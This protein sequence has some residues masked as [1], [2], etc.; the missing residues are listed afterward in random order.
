MHL[1][2]VKCIYILAISVT[3][4]YEYD[5]QDYAWTQIAS[6]SPSQY[7]GKYGITLISLPAK[8]WNRAGRSLQ[9]KAEAEAYLKYQAGLALLDELEKWDARPIDAPMGT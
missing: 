2:L 1:A 8:S 7:P 4:T 6:P 3:G 5:E 9:R